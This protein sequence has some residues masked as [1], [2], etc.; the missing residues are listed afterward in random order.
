MFS[1]TR[2]TLVNKAAIALCAVPFLL[3]AYVTGPDPRHTG[4]PGDAAQACATAGCHT[5]TALNGG[6]GKVEIEFPNGLTYV[7]G[8]KQRWTVRVTDSAQRVFG[9]QATARLES[10]PSAGQA[11]TFTNI[12]NSTQI[13]CDDG[14][15]RPSAGCRANF[16]VE[17]IEHTRG[18]SANTFTFEWTPPATD[19]GNVRVYVAGN[20]ANGNGTNSGDRIYAANYTLTA[21]TGGGGGQPRPAISQ[22]GVADAF[23]FQAGVAPSTWTAIF[24]TNLAATTKTWDD[25]ISGSTLPTTL[26]GVS[27]T[28]GEKPATIYFVSPGQINVLAPHDIGTGTM[29]VV[30]KNSNGE[31]TPLTVTAAAVK[32]AFYAISSQNNRLF[33]TAVATQLDASGR[34]VFVGKP[35]LQDS[36]VSRGARPGEILQV[37]G[38][39]FG[40]TN[41]VVP[42][43]Q[44]V[45]G[46]PTITSQVRIR[47][48]ET[49]ATFAG[50][51]N[52]V[53]A[54]LYQFNVTVPDTLSDGDYPL[55]AEVGGVTSSSNV[56]I[57]V[58]R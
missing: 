53:A 16:S 3:Y 1:N 12:D 40:A 46:A 56:Y 13:L 19:V 45:S 33:V 20:A 4:A 10:N 29:N 31:S 34:P 39:G 26:E 54:G 17:F 55:I 43:N 50:S 18:S 21:T 28:I 2:N 58:Q 23:S 35:G 7:P 48:G 38:T 8:T 6:P 11:G 9:F 41:P 57:T 36:R 47:F 37:F 15:V 25:A 51:G 24:G 44:I 32:P 27:V 52:L 14:A 30:V 49:V 5:G 42:S 22:G